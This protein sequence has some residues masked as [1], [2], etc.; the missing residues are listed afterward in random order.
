MLKFQELIYYIWGRC[1]CVC[2]SILEGLITKIISQ[3]NTTHVTETKYDCRCLIELNL[4]NLYIFDVN[5]DDAIGID[6]NVM[7]IV[8]YVYVLY[9]RK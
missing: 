3:N 2:G 1:G 5:L 4:Q 9:M 7:Y 8:S 6:L